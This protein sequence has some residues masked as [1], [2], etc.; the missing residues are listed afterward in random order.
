ML[1]KGQMSIKQ[2]RIQLNLGTR[3]TFLVVDE[4]KFWNSFP[5][6]DV[7]AKKNSNAF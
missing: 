6:K 1:A 4:V 2:S 3:R 5:V 7:G